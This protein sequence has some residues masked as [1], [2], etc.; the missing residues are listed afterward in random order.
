MHYIQPFKIAVLNPFLIFHKRA[1][2]EKHT[3]TSF[4]F[5]GNFSGRAPVG[6]LRGPLCGGQLRLHD[7]GCHSER[8]RD[9]AQYESLQPSSLRGGL[10]IDMV[11]ENRKKTD[12]ECAR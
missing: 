9:S 1:H 7:R 3:Q 6:S 4:R 5:G 2:H 11:V 12:K 8:G 10:G